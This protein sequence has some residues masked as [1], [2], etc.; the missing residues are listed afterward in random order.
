MIFVMATLMLCTYSKAA[1]SASLKGECEQYMIES[2]RLNEIPLGVLYAIG[3]T[4]TG[5]ANSLQ[6]Y[7]LNIAGK[8]LYP[9]SFQQALK[10]INQATESG[11]RMID[12]GCM[13]I[14]FR[15]H[16]KKFA[17]VGDM[18]D[19]RQN[20]AYAAGF[21]KKLFQREGSWTLAAARYHAGPD[22]L[23]A[24][25][26]YVC[27]VISNLVASGFGRWTSKSRSFCS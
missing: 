23:V 18:L 13:Q 1:V 15:Y 24:Q 10:L 9:T 21:L 14:N 25:K 7:A 2:A 17:S 6:P 22:N 19:A 4:E 5:R 20:V 12:I 27:A 8:P 3:L 11:E 16:A 26:R